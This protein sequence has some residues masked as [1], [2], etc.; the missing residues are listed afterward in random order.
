MRKVILFATVLIAPLAF[1]LSS[2]SGV[3]QHP[4]RT[5]VFKRIAAEE[6][7]STIGSEALHEATNLI[8]HRLTG[9]EHGKKAEQYAFDLFKK[10]GFKNVE[11]HDFE[12]DAWSREMVKL[13]LYYNGPDTNTVIPLGNQTFPSKLTTASAG[14]VTNPEVVSL[15][16]SPVKADVF[17][18]M[19]DVGNGLNADYESHKE[20]IRG[21]IVVLNLGIYPKDSALKNLHRSEKTALAI[22]YGAAGCIFINNVS[23]RILLTG[24]ASVNGQLISIPAVCV[25]QEDGLSIRQCLGLSRHAYAR[26]AMINHSGKIKA[27]NVVATLKGSGL[28]EE[29]IIL[30]GHLDSWD[31]ATGAIDNGIGSFTVLEI[32]RIF[33]KLKIKPRR[34]IRFITF[35]GEEQGLLGSKA[36]VKGILANGFISKLRY[37]INLDMAGNTDGFNVSGRPEMEAFT[38]EVMTDIKA[39]EP[40]FKATF[41]NSAGLHSDHQP[42]LE[43]GIPILEPE[44]RLDPEVYKFYHSNKDD[45]SLVNPDHMSRCATFVGMMLYALAD[46]K[47]IPAKRL[48]DEETMNFFIK[49]KLKKELILGE[50][51]R[52]EK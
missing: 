34:T 27:R 12:V 43:Q 48:S 24:T 21:K 50:E 47:E 23:G 36:Y 9:S 46:A 3:V 51:W 33:E 14:C 29:E 1:L 11:F 6:L 35:M 10:Y 25:T 37:V 8:G 18:E 26:I 31:L 20:A 17:A 44:G 52:W 5:S 28:P 7:H 19:I 45:F 30:C 41:A 38:K 22:Q 15:A 13:N 16:H 42:F 49:A 40:S 39:A 4:D 32:A 2:S